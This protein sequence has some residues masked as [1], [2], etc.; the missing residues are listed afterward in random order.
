MTAATGTVI[1]FN[2]TEE[3]ITVPAGTIVA[4][5][6]GQRFE[7]TDTVR[8][9]ARQAEFF[10]NVPVGIKAGQVEVGVRALALGVSEM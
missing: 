3:E 5:D 1:L 9:P 2:E 6:G 7:V 8:V 4:T 10:M